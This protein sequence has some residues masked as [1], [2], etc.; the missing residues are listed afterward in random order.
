MDYAAAKRMPVIV[1][2]RW[3]SHVDPY[4]LLVYG[5][6]QNDLMRSAA[7]YV[8]KILEGTRPGDL[9]VLQPAKFELVVNLRTAK[10]IALEVPSSILVR[11]DSVIE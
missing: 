8:V 7:G 10:R 4:P 9:P 2:F 3:R 6:S 1:D 5:A 11:A